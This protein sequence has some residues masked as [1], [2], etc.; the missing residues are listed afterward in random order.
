MVRKRFMCKLLAGVIAAGSLLTVTASFSQAKDGGSSEITNYTGADRQQR[1][2][3]GA[4]KEGQLL[5]YTSLPVDDMTAIIKAFESKYGI[6]VK[7][8]RAGGEKVMQRALGETRASRFDVDILETDGPELEALHREGVLQ[9]VTSPYM[10]DLI[11]QAIT[12]HGEWTSTRLNIF[13]MAYNTNLVKK[14]ELP[15]TYQDLLD[16]KWKG[17]LGVEAEDLDWF[18]G[19]V[20]ELGEEKGLQLFRDIVASNGISVRKGHTLLTNLVASGE[21]PLALTV[22]NYKAE[23]L[24]KKG[25]PLDWFTI[26]PAIARGNGVAMVKGAPH[27]HAAVL[28]YDFMLSDAQDILLKRHFVPTSKKVDTQLNKMPLKFAD[29][30]IVLDESEKWGKLYNQIITRQSK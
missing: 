22:Y 8:W 3:Q 26:D 18:A 14:A 10:A 5:I 25:A 23:Q 30:K 17:K 27:P 20:G 16:P 4:K 15:K 12:S 1:L 6:K 9:K 21:V 2:E 11:P 28:F 19:V 24:K 7:L 13:A 29:P